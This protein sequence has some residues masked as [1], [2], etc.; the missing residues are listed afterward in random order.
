MDVA[1]V[2]KVRVEG[3]GVRKEIG[4][5]H[6]PHGE[7]DAPVEWIDLDICKSDIV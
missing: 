4:R 2:M 6:K 3:L 5:Q 1:E 7:I